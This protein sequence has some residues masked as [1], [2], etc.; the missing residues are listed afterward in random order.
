MIRLKSI[1][2]LRRI[3]Q[4]QIGQSGDTLTMFDANS[5]CSY[6]V[7]ESVPVQHLATQ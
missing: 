6:P 7:F 3:S 5:R 1:G 4:T 2:K